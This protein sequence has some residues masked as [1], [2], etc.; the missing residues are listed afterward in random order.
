MTAY[1][2]HNKSFYKK[3]TDILICFFLVLITFCV[4]SQ[5][6]DHSFIT[7][8]DDLYVTKNFHVQNGLTGESIAWAFSFNDVFYWHPLTWLSH[9]LD[10]QLYGLNAGM[11]HL[12]NLILHIIN[13]LLLFFVF[14]QVTG[15]IWRSA[16]VAALFALHPINVESV[17][18]VAERKNVLSTFFWLLTM[19]AY[20]YYVRR[21]SIYRY[22]LVFVF[23]ILGLLSKP[24][25]ATLPFV[26]LLIDYWPLERVKF[27]K[28]CF[29][30]DGKIG[31][32]IF[33]VQKESPPSSLV[34]EKIPLIFLSSV[35]ILV[36]SVSV[37]RFGIILSID[38]KTMV[39][40]IENALVSYIKYIKNAFWP[41]DLT[42]IYPYPDMIPV[43]QSVGAGL[44]LF[45]ITAVSVWKIKTKPYFFVG[46]LWYFVSL[47]P[48]I[49]LVQAGF[50]PAMADRWAYI[51]TIG[52][53]IILVWSVV[54]LIKEWHY[55]EIVLV[56]AAGLALLCLMITS[57]Q[58]IQYWKNSVTIYKQAIDATERNY[59]AHN[60]LGNV[61]YREGKT[62]KAVYHYNEALRINPGYPFAHNNLGAAMIRDG[63]IERAI[64][65]FQEALRIKPDYIEA[66]N[67]LRKTLKYKN[68]KLKNQ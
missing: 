9:M 51:P 19:L 67:N 10:C 57:S 45:L 25:L 63:K 56:A 24:M 50:W 33:S 17:A 59:L 52:I 54:D 11:H 30:K 48:V 27:G 34:L 20:V 43:W 4:Y 18:W 46:W 68:N 22:L 14:K 2:T 28:I 8:D 12:T 40:R 16:F 5:L 1:H 29:N 58:Q 44:L 13:C 32:F 36:T 15:A 6:K 42:F 39:L 64:F 21:P 66:N 26:L 23:F 53:F 3:R 7:Y 37:H 47:I 31:K 38:S 61:Y 55:K 62:A 65:H 49:G 60:N 35:S 41:N